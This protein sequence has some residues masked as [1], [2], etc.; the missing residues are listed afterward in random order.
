MAVLTRR[1]LRLA[2][3]GLPGLEALPDPLPN[4]LFEVLERVLDLALY[5]L[6]GTK[7]ALVRVTSNMDIKECL[8]TFDG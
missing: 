4:Q 5:V 6:G 1:D 3:T 8:L 2:S 7:K